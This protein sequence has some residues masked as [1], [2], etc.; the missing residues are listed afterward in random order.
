MPQNEH[1]IQAQHALH[2]TVGRYAKADTKLLTKP[3][4]RQGDI[5]SPSQHGHFISSQR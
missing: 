4:L 2:A 3:V 1:T 5:P